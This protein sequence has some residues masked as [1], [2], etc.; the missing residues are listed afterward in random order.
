MRKLTSLALAAA[1]ILGGAIW[2]DQAKADE[3]PVIIGAAIALS[4]FVQPYDDG[5]LKAAMLAIEDINAKGGVLGRPMKLVTADTKSDPAQGTNAAIEVLE[6]GAEMVI[7]TCDFDFGVAAAMAAQGAG[8]I[9]FSSCA[10][11]PKFGVQGIGPLAYTMALGTPAQGATL[12]EWAYNERGWRKAYVVM[13]T[14][15]EYFKSLC[16]NFKI[17]WQ[18]L[19]GEIAGEDTYHGIN[20]TAFDGH[21]TRLKNNADA[22]M[23]FLCGATFGAPGLLRQIRAAGIDTPIL[24]SESMDGN[25]WLEAV[26]DLSNYYI[27][28]YGSVYGNDPDPMVR[29]YVEKFTALHGAPPVTAHSMTGYSLIQA[30]TR[31]AER[32]GSFEA[33]AIR[34][35]LDKFDEEPLLVGKTSFSPDLHINLHRSLLIMEVQNGKHTPIGRFTA[36]KV[37]PIKF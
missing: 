6:E 16:G 32:A 27:G 12:A 13:D 8:K 11:D 10:G 21:V 5:P 25:F 35:E 7:V 15:V 26:P 33:E 36:E 28:V 9:A 37:P 14:I 17:R 19:G 34:T 2:A 24:A 1:L 20:D 31:A 30:W 23:V 29:N 4:G 18:E 3:D 22:D